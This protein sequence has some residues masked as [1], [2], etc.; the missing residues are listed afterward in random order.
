[1]ESE[2]KERMTIQVSLV[3]AAVDDFNNKP[4]SRSNLRVWIEGAGPSISKEEG[5]YVFVNLR[6]PQVEVCL[7]GPMYHAQRIFLD[8]ERLLG[9]QGKVL[10]VRMQPNRAYPIPKNT[11]CVQGYAQPGSCI[12]A[13][14]KDY[15]NPFKLLYAYQKNSSEIHIFH[16]ED[17]DIEGKTFVIQTKDGS[18]K[19]VFH[20]IEQIDAEK[21]AYL[22]DKPMDNEYKKIGTVI[23]PVYVFEANQNGEFYLP[24]TGIAGENASFVFWQEAGTSFETELTAGRVNSIRV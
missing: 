3:V 18:Q 9:L 21:R 17:F 23:Y 22:L 20:V 16:A 12:M 13:Y 6:E 19:D 2:C 11:T 15:G 1:M 7:E 10:K 8:N 4:I 14:N 24:I 5:Y